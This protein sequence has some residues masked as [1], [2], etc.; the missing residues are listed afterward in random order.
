MRCV[1]LPVNVA[2]RALSF[3]HALFFLLKLQRVAI[4]RI[5]H[6]VGYEGSETDSLKKMGYDFLLRDLEHYGP[7]EVRTVKAFL[8]HTKID[9][10]SEKCGWIDWCND[11]TLR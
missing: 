8:D 6:M 9:M 2:R 10:Q 1:A 11:C 3:S 7:G 4:Q 5:K